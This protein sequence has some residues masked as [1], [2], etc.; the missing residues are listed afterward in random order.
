MIFEGLIKKFYMIKLPEKFSIKDDFPE[1]SF[2][3]WKKTV[4]KDY[5]SVPP[6]KRLKTKTFEGIYLQF[7][8]TKKDIENL[9]EVSNKPGFK[10]FVRGTRPDGYLDNSWLIAQEIQNPIPEEFNSALKIDLERGQNAININLDKSYQ[11]VVN[12]NKFSINGLV[13]QNLDDLGKAFDNIDLTRYP[14]FV[15]TGYSNLHFLILFAAYAKQKGYDIKKLTGAIESDPVNFAVSEGYLPISE[16]AIF[17][18]MYEATKWSINNSPA[19][20]TIGVNS[21]QY[22]NSGANIIQEIS[23]SISTAV[24]YIRQMLKRGLNINEISRNIRFTFGISSLYF[25]EIS[26][27]RAVKMLWAKVIE[28]FGGDEESQKIFIH[29]RTSYNNQTIY[30]PYVNMLRTTTEAFSAVIGGVDSLQT[31]SFDEALGQADEFSRRIARNTQ[32][33]LS[34]ESHLNQLIDPAGGS[35]F[36]ENLTNEIAKKSWDSFREIESKGGIFKALESG[37]IKDE[38]EK[39]ANEKKTNFAK[40]KITQVGINAYANVKEEKLEYEI[41]DYSKALKSRY[42]KYNKLK[43]EKG[44]IESLG[45]TKKAD[46]MEKLFASASE[47]YTKG[48]YINDIALNSRKNI[49]GKFKIEPLKIFRTAEIFEELRDAS[50]EFKNKNGFLPK[51]L[52]LQ[53]GTLKQYK[54][55]ADF[56]KSFFEIGGFEVDSTQKCNT[57]EEAIDSGLNSGSKIVVICSTDDTYPELVPPIVK[58]IKGKNKDIIIVLAGYPK[59]YVDQ[60]K[61]DGVDEFIYL[62]ADVHKTLKTIMTK[63]GVII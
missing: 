10:N 35:Y 38:I 62:G 27:L 40:R 28:S 29:A 25:L 50:L 48:V 16:E 41:P 57:A 33:I 44:Y 22:H 2:E 12:E 39:I 52:L 36:V 54:G 23:Y 58:G 20:K 18:E 13:I 30:D 11:E 5:E 45:R 53:M 3:D 6:E 24:E 63:T 31:N 46:T 56:S 43:K 51:V 21:I 47:A 7:I 59:D 17:N 55:R 9:P 26:K 37:F 14:I 60:F 49:A 8:Y 19:L 32:I 61:Q 4:E 1:T 34:E 15:K 42:E